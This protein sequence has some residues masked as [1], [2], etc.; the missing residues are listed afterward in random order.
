[1]GY[2]FRRF[3]EVSGPRPL[4]PA[5]IDHLWGAGTDVDS[6]GNSRTPDDREWTELYVAKR[7]ECS[8]VV[9]VSP[10][11]ESPLVLAVASDSMDLAERAAKF[12]ANHTNGRLVGAPVGGHLT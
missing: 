11:S 12:I 1:M 6:D 5:V 7:P 2:R 8:E 4:F 9:D 3:V 10:A